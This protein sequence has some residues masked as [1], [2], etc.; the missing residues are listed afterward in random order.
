MFSS[1]GKHRHNTLEDMTSLLN[2]F[3]YPLGHECPRDSAPLLLEGDASM[4]PP[5]PQH[6]N[7][8]Y[9]LKLINPSPNRLQQLITQM[10][11]RLEE[12]TVLSCKQKERVRKSNAQ[13][14]PYS[15][16]V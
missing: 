16:Q 4:L 8:E 2:M 7:I 3:D 6:G 11:W 14:L 12:G 13:Q 10:K 15:L 9:K 5:E 1:S